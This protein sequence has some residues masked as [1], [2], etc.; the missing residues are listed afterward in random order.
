MKYQGQSDQLWV[1]PLGDQPKE[2]YTGVRKNSSLVKTFQFSIRMA[3]HLIINPNLCVRKNSSLVK[4]FQFSIRMARDLLESC[5]GTSFVL[6]FN[7]HSLSKAE[8][9]P[10]TN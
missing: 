8:S 10:Q 5:D 2:S 1:E 3:S 4:T 6:E 7:E 9:D